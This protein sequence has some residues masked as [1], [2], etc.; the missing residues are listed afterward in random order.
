MKLIE[1]NLDQDKTNI[2]MWNTTNDYN[3]S[4]K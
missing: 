3:I 2:S 4:S 1:K